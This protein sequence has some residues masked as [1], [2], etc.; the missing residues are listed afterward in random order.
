MKKDGNQNFCGDYHPLN[1]QIRQDSF[2][3]P[4]I[5]NVLNQLRHSKWFSTLDLQSGFWQISMA[6]NDVK[7]TT[8]ITKS[9]LY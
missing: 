4:L 1:H 8:V 9:S 6:P 2:P 5:Q 7:K 3:M